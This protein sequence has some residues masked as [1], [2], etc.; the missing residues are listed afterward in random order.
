MKRTLQTLLFALIAITMPI[1]IW[2]QAS[3]VEAKWGASAE[4]LNNEGTLAQALDAAA[5]NS[6]VAYIQLQ[7]DISTNSNSTYITAGTFTLDLNS[8]TLTS[9][10]FTLDIINEGT[11]VILT[12]NSATSTGKI[13]TLGNVAI[14]VSVRDGANLTINGGSYE[15][16]Y[17]ALE[18]NSNSSAT[19]TGG[20]F[21]GGKD[22]ATIYNSDGTL[23]ITGGS[24]I[25]N[26]NARASV[27]WGINTVNTIKGGAFTCGRDGFF[28]HRGGRVD[29]T[30]YPT[31]KTD[32][33]TPIQHIILYNFSDDPITVND[34]TI[35]L[36]AGYCFYNREEQ[37]VTELE[38]NKSFIIGAQERGNEAKWGTSAESL[39]N[40]G[41]LAQAFKAAA[42]DN[43]VAYIQIQSDVSTING[44]SIDYGNFTLDLNSHI[45]TSNKSTLTTNGNT[46]VI[47][48]DN[49]ASATGKVV[50]YSSSNA[51]VTATGNSSL[52]ITGGS[53]ESPFIA[54]S[55]IYGSHSTITDG[56]FIGG[57]YSIYNDGNLTISGGSFTGTKGFGASVCNSQ[58]SASIIN[59]GTFAYGLLGSFYYNGSRFDM[60]GYPTTETEG[61][62]PLTEISVYNEPDNTAVRDNSITLPLG[63]CFYNS[64]KQPVTTLAA[65][66][67]YTID[68][69]PAIKYTVT[70]AANGGSG[71]MNEDFCYG[72]DY[73]L[74]ECTFTAPEK[75]QFKAWKIG[76]TEYQPG[77]KITVDA[78]TT[79]T[80]VWTDYVTK[81]ILELTDSYGDGW[82]DA[83]IIVKKDGVEI[84]TATIT[85]K[86]TSSATFQYE[87]DK[88][89]EYTFYWKKS[90]F[91]N[92]CSFIISIEDEMLLT[93]D[94]DKCSL[95]EDGELIYTI[96]K[97]LIDVTITDGELTEY[98]NS[99]KKSINTLTYTRT[100]PNTEWNSLYVP[101][102]IPVDEELLANYEVAYANNMHAYDTDNNGEIDKLEMEVIKIMQGTLHANHPYFIR[103]KS[104]TAQAITLTLEDAILH[105]TKDTVITCQS[106]YTTFAL[107]G[108]Y[109]T[110]DADDFSAIDGKHYA[111]STEGGWWRTE[112]LGAFRVYMT[113]TQR[114]GS[115]VKVSEQ[116][117][118]S[119]GISVAGEGT[120]GIEE[121]QEQKAESKEIFD[122]Q[123]RKVVNPDKGIYIVNG[124]KILIK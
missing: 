50:G 1:G 6:A 8:H 16:Q 34:N 62:T 84:G 77:E 37:A 123:G 79:V 59:G 82:N 39:T 90:V 61:T 32:G 22:L 117:M 63:Y 64:D 55:I 2:A 17:I 119:V 65:A 92:E 31:T 33:T 111:I 52:T 60:T 102:E 104:E 38:S 122:L 27:F 29:L 30:G 44:H 21:K 56:S 41:T 98:S 71:T 19:I 20:S 15:S 14:A 80:A 118:R 28:M 10:T 99:I 87:H 74:A 9:N 51:T 36:P 48:T 35:A 12:D 114:E 115:P 75:K 58:N 97:E 121:M 113:I 66:Q 103:A 86:E 24:F 57:L 54:I 120:T 85:G 25:C 93:A 83:A 72:G 67:K 45:L 96:E 43:T 3:T 108:I 40:E 26:S 69:E 110:M 78:N 112:G 88:N 81:I 13:T 109:N 47:I 7:R 23:T 42:D 95:Y 5:N 94:G 68:K 89:C 124:K 105:A 53:Y 11:N 18:I 107:T 116:A 49:S 106:F 4:S 100:L 76:D 73:I 70:Y 91:D 101:F 46:N